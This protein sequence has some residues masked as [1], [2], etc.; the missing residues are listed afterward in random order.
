MKDKAQKLTKDAQSADSNGSKHPSVLVPGSEGQSE[1]DGAKYPGGL[2]G[3]IKRRPSQSSVGGNGPQASVADPDAPLHAEGPPLVAEKPQNGKTRFADT[4]TIVPP[5]AGLSAGTDAEVP[6]HIVPAG[7]SSEKLKKGKPGSSDTLADGPT[8]EPV[9]LSDG[10]TAYLLPAP[11]P[12]GEAGRESDGAAAGKKD[13]LSKPLGE[14]NAANIP[15]ATGPPGS[16]HVASLP[17]AESELGRGHCSVCCPS[18]PRDN[19]AAP[20]EPCVHLDPSAV[21]VPAPASN[22]KGAKKL[23]KERPAEGVSGTHGAPPAGPLGLPGSIEGDA[24]NVPGEQDGFGK[25]PSTTGPNK[26]SKGKKTDLS[27]EEQLEDDRARAGE[28]CDSV[29]RTG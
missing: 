12:A 1:G 28:S 2:R 29:L 20:V 5:A 15:S 9:I 24:A 14:S 6:A 13:K 16:T 25:S 3:L 11:P 4:A 27:P 19:L 23:G 10:R 18:A 26:L 22:G 21:A 7:S 17:A 8:L